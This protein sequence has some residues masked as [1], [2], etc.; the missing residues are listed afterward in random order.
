MT[1]D[2]DIGEEVGWQELTA[3]TAVGW[4]AIPPA[5]RAH[6]VVLTANYGEAGAIAHYGPALGLPTPWSGHM[7]LWFWGP[8]PA[9]DDGPVLLVHPAHSAALEQHFRDCRP[10]ARVDNGHGT[11]N[12][13]QH[14]A[15]VLCAGPDRSWAALWPLLRRY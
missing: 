14:A 2:P 8:P 4:A 7:G 1:V 11:P 6:A 10:V 12:M 9:A 15:V 5:E 3:A 13:E